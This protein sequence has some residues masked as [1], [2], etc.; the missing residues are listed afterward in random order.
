VPR[1]Q[2]P[3]RT[4]LAQPLAGALIKTDTR[5]HGIIGVFV[6]S[7]EVFHPRDE[8]GVRLGDTPR[9]FSPRFARVVF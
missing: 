8:L 5:A 6:Q 2:G 9:L 1:H 7:E 3:G 4:A